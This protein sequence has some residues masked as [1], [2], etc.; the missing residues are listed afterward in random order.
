MLN[1]MLRAARECGV[2]AA[3]IGEDRGLVDVGGDRGDDDL[4]K[5]VEDERTGGALLANWQGG[6]MAPERR[7]LG[8]C[9]ACACAPPCLSM[10]KDAFATARRLGPHPSRLQGAAA[11]L[12]APVVAPLALP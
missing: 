5:A 3:L 12:R 9:L 2:D 1:G 7:R 10:A 8:R 4:A 11:V 6:G